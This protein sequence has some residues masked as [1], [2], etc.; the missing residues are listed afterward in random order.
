MKNFQRGRGY[1]PG[2]QTGDLKQRRPS[3]SLGLTSL[4]AELYIGRGGPRSTIPNTVLSFMF[5]RAPIRHTWEEAK[6][7]SG[8]VPPP[9]APRARFNNRAFGLRKRGFRTLA[10]VSAATGIPDTTLCRWEGKRIPR[11]PRVDGIRAIPASQ[12]DDY[13]RHC[14]RARNNAPIS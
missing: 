11:L 3:V 13:V 5:A 4:F 10:E 8:Y 14:Q 1:K 12:F 6:R 7:I 9:R 2:V